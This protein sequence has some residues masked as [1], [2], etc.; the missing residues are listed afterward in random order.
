ML[1]L[2][3]DHDWLSI[4]SDFAQVITGII[5][6]IATV[7]I[8]CQRCSRRKTLENYLRAEL[9]RSKTSGKGAAHTIIHLMANCSMTEPQI[10][11]AAFASSKIEHWLTVDKDTNL[12]G[13]MLLRFKDST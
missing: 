3:A 6:V 7:W 12:A 8:Y 2:A 9:K 5:A 13:E 10:L 1:G 4:I 11:E